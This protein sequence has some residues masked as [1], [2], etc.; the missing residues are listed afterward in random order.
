MED[1]EQKAIRTAANPPTWWIY[2]DDTHTKQKRAHSQ[3]FTDHLN[4]IDDDIK[5][6]TEP[7]VTIP[8]SDQET[9]GDRTERA[10]AFL[11]TWSVVNEDGSIKTRVFRKATHTDQYLNFQS[12]HPLEHK[13]GVVRTLAHRAEAIVSDP[14][15]KGAELQHVKTALSFNGYPSWILKDP[16]HQVQA[17]QQPTPPTRTPSTAKNRYPVV[18][19][20]IKGFSEELRRIL[21]G[22]N[23]QAYFKP[24]N[25]LRQ[26]L[27]RPKDKLDKHQV[28]GPVYHIPCG[29]CPASYV[30]ETERSLKARFLE[31]RRPSSTTSEV[32]RHIHTAEPGHN[33]DIENAKV[34]EV[35]P[36]W[37]ERGVKE[38][39]HIRTLQPTLN[40]DGGRHNRSP[41]W[42]NILRTR[43]RRGAQ[44]NSG[45]PP[46]TT[47]D[48]VTSDHVTKDSA[49]SESL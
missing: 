6:T 38:A 39:I 36:R 41:I 37:Y 27:V 49:E 46:I 11:D 33:I 21:K 16:K 3:Q 47:P 32:S 8:V 48:D 43:V 5:W 15:D 13:R 20:Y 19:P 28:T 7:E 44:S 31:H 22:Y 42:S 25:T 9:V 26:L 24:T 30:G 4:S 29:D 10:L 12:N 2:V 45:S 17:E 35:E 40:K 34:F 23:I 1:F 14:K 18:L